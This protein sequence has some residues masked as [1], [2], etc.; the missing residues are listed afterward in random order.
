MEPVLLPLLLF[1][2]LLQRSLHSILLQLLLLF[3]FF[4]L[5]TLHILCLEVLTILLLLPLLLPILF[6]CPY[7]PLSTSCTPLA[8][9]HVAHVANSCAVASNAPTGVPRMHNGSASCATVPSNRWPTPPRGW[10][11]K[12]PSIDRSLSTRC[13]H[14]VKSTFPSATAPC[15]S[16][17]NKTSLSFSLST[18]FSF[19][20]RRLRE[21]Q[22]SRR[23]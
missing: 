10:R 19:A 17:A 15:V 6:H 21:C 1:S 2:L 8:M 9:S 3:S 11:N 23:Q 22:P 7:S 5:L 12:C 18:N 16:R 20:P 14:A 13:V 4:L